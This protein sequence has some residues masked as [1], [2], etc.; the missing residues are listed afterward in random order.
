MTS[1]AHLLAHDDEVGIIFQIDY[2]TGDILKEFQVGNKKLKEDF[3]VKYA[4]IPD[5]LEALY[6]KD[7]INEAVKLDNITIMKYNI[8]VLGNEKCW[9]IIEE[10]TNPKTRLNYR[11]IFFK[12]GGIIPEKE[13]KW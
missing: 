7:L 6:N 8:K 13:I 4:K 12:A 9:Y 10:F 3:E 5:E 2:K 11:N 1:D